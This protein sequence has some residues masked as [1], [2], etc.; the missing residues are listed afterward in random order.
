MK[1]IILITITLLMASISFSG[2]STTVPSKKFD[3]SSYDRQKAAAAT[4]Q[5]EL[6]EDM[7]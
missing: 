5:S 1:K 3:K 6:K 4:A 7:R 2:C